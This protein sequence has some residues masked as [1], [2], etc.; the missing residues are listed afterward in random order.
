MSYVCLLF[1]Q[2][3]CEAPEEGACSAKAVAVQKLAEIDRPLGLGRLN[4]H[5][6]ALI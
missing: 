3:L 6:F 1:F 2:D 4:H 5:L